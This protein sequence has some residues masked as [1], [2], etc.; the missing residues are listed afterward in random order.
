MAAGQVCDNDDDELSSAEESC[1]TEILGYRK[2]NRMVPNWFEHYPNL[3][4]ITA[5]NPLR[6]Y[7]GDTDF[8]SLETPEVPL[9]DGVDK[10]SGGEVKIG[11]PGFAEHGRIE[12]AAEFEPARPHYILP[13]EVSTEMFTS[14]MTQQNKVYLELASLLSA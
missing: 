10:D 7:Q 1:D 11:Q 14:H 13:D 9:A 12:V 6:F 4:A 8:P 3:A 5:T 2:S